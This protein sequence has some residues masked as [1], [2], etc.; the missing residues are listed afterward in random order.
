M[1]KMELQG[2]LSKN[3]STMKVSPEAP[4][5]AKGVKNFGGSVHMNNMVV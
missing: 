2:K 5:R 1:D 3:I 4:Y